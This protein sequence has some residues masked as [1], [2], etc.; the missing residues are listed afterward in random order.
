MKVEEEEE[1]MEERWAKT[2]INKLIKSSTRGEVGYLLSVTHGNKRCWPVDDSPHTHTH[3]D[4]VCTHSLLYDNRIAYTSSRRKLT[5]LMPKSACREEGRVRMTHTPVITL[6]P[7]PHH[8]HTNGRDEY[9]IWMQP[10]S[11]PHPGNLPCEAQTDS[12]RLQLFVSRWW[13]DVLG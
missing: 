10:T 9:I 2:W 13:E 5:S 11:S 7:L 4:H 3:T 6:L 12:V 8:T 1:A